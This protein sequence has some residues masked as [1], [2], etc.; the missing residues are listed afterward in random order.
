MSIVSRAFKHENV[1][2]VY[3]TMHKQLWTIGQSQSRFDF[4]LQGYHPCLLLVLCDWK[5]QCLIGLVT[6]IRAFPRKPKKTQMWRNSGWYSYLIKGK[7]LFCLLAEMHPSY[8]FISFDF[9]RW[10]QGLLLQKDKFHYRTIRYFMD[11]TV[12]INPVIAFV[13]LLNY[14]QL[15]DQ[16]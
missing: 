12:V 2:F 5:Q 4:F 14:C 11:W 10:K 7:A 3:R 8:V 13:I 6:W 15:L 16:V 1:L 9:D